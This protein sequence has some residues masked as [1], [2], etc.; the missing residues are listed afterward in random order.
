MADSKEMKK[1]TRFTFTNNK[2]T[3]LTAPDK[4]EAARPDSSDSDQEEDPTGKKR[5]VASRA[6]KKEQEQKEKESLLKKRKRQERSDSSSSNGSDSSDRRL[7]KERKK[8]KKAEKRAKKEKKEK[9]EKKRLEER[10]ERWVPPERNPWTQRPF[11]DRFFDILQ[12]RKELPAWHAR[13]QVIDLVNEFQ[14][15]ILQGE[16]GSGKTTQV[17]QFLLDSGIAGDKNVACTQPRRV[18][19]MSVAKRVSEEMDVQL[20]GTVGY[21]IRFEDKTGP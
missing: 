9:K 17:P 20:G 18:A 11:T 19:A 14:V 1:A 15:V 21:T 12:K 16:T 10:A 7:K 13:Q 5:F 6:Q 3:A 8:Q 4:L 2:D